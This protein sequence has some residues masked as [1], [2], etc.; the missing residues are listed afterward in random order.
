VRI[1]PAVEL[2]HLKA[3]RPVEIDAERSDDPAWQP[4]LELEVARVE[5]IDAG[6]SDVEAIP[7]QRRGALSVRTGHEGVVRDQHR[8]AALRQ[9]QCAGQRVRLR[10]RGILV[11][12]PEQRGPARGPVLESGHQPQGGVV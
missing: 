1:V 11:Q 12:A 10:L 2:E 9:R 3:E 5:R 7:R 6:R 8:G 4:R